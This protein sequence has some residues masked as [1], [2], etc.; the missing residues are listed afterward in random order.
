MSGGS[1]NRVGTANAGTTPAGLDAFSK[2]YQGWIT[3]YPD[4]RRGQRGPAAGRRRPAPRR[5]G[6]S[7]TPTDVDWKFEEHKGSG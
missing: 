3:P 6:S 5:T 4:R 1:W 2:S 7:T